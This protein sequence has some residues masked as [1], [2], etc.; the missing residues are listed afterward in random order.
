MTCGPGSRQ[1]AIL[2]ILSEVPDE[3]WALREI[4]PLVYGAEQYTSA[5][6]QSV[7]KAV[8]RLAH[9]GLVELNLQKYHQ[10]YG[11]KTHEYQIRVR[12]GGP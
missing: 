10:G 11:G 12:G 3:L 8:H 7:R 5:Q 2:A 9:R 4:V 1:R 6:Y